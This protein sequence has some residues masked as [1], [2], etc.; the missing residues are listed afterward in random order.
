[1]TTETRMTFSWNFK[2]TEDSDTATHARTGA[3]AAT[4]TAARTM[5]T[6]GTAD[7]TGQGNTGLTK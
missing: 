2:W 1:M 7:K 6:I 3:C 5:S 4:A